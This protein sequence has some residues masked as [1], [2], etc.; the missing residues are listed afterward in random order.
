M[1]TISTDQIIEAVKD[2]CID[3]AC[4]LNDD[5]REKI[6]EAKQQEESPFAKSILDQLLENARIAKEDRVPLCQDTGMAV[7]FLRLGQDVHITGGSLYAAID[8]GVRRGY[9][10]GYLRKSVL[11]PLT[12]ENTG[13]NSPA[14]IHTEI[15]DGDRLEITL[16]PKGFG[17]E[18]MSKLA[19]LKP[20][21]GIEGIKAFVLDT[22]I[23]AG[24][25][26]CPPIIV[27]IGIGGTM[28]KAAYIAKRSLLRRLGEKNPDPQL[29]QLELEL[30]GLVNS[31]GIG[32][33]GLG[34]KT[35]ALAVHIE[36]FPTHI[37]G[38]PVAINIQC[39]CARHRSISL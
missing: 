14:V 22:V 5:I 35:T 11:D 8:E 6:K 7:V 21:D 24:A 32:P 27:G 34:G 39:H 10:Q 30:L 29:A 12:R 38:L 23:E 25:N 19:M 15:V 18:N 36:A 9:S 13:D 2:L 17:S 26:P 4:I 37:A 16:A 1:R 20:S 31:T 33:Q 3:A 28:D